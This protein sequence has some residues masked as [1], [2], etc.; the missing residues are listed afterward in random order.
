MKNRAEF[1]FLIVLSRGGEGK[2][3]IEHFFGNEK[4]GSSAKSAIQNQLDLFEN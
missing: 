4:R 3:Y 2:L 1:V